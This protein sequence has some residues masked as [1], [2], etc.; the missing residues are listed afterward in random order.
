[1]EAYM[2]GHMEAQM[3]SELEAQKGTMWKPYGEDN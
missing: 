3:E 1:M 2:K